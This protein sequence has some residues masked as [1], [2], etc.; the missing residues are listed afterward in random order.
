M[1]V[2]S[3]PEAPE[4]ISTTDGG[5][6]GGGGFSFSSLGGPKLNDGGGGEGGGGGGY[7]GGEY[8]TTRY[9]PMAWDLQVTSVALSS[10]IS[11][12]GSG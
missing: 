4:R 12:H 1:R 2:S 8:C 3:P 11:V 6:G 5:G 9:S 10:T 7:A